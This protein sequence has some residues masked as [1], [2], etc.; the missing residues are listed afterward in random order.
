MRLE[1]LGVVQDLAVA[2]AEDVRGV[3]A[4]EA[5]QA[6]LEAGGE[7]RL[8][9]RLAG[10]EV[11]APEGRARLLR[12]LDEGGNVRGEVGGA[13]RVGDAR[14]D[15]GVGVD[16]RGRDLGVV[17]LEA[18]LELLQ[19]RVH[20][21]R[22]LVDLGGAAPDHHQPRE[23]VLLLEAEDVRGHLLGEVPLVLALLDALSPQLLD[24]GGVEDGGPG[25]HGLQEGLQRLEVLVVEHARLARG[26]VGVVLEDVP[27][28]EDHVFQAGEG[29]EL[30]DPAGCDRPC[31]CPAG[32][33]PSG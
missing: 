24:V 19:R 15:R 9:E 1:R 28:P 21:A 2:V 4:V 10:L 12:E 11:L 18:P 5:E 22:L 32:P 30:G 29:H 16:H 7:E 17:E 27:A 23:V 8:H 14:L 13:V 33:C 26:L 31:A 6:R 20:L 3:P 25:P